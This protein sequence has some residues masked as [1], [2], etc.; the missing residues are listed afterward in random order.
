MLFFFL[1]LIV[2]S[3]MLSRH[4]PRFERKKNKQKEDHFY[5]MKHAKIRVNKA[6]ILSTMNYVLVS[7][8]Y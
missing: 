1:V 5:M 6:Q 7:H 4:T 8:T 2:S 3:S